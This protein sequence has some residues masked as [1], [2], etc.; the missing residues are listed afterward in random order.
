MF[1]DSSGWKVF[2][3]STVR[4]NWPMSAHASQAFS[5]AHCTDLEDL[6]SG[7]PQMLQMAPDVILKASGQFFIG[8]L[9]SVTLLLSNI[10][11]TNP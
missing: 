8:P 4:Y 10:P 11:A 7:W 9:L 3:I 1:L 5:I 2:R 6:P